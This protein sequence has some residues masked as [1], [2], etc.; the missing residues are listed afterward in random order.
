MPASTVPVSSPEARAYCD[1]IQQFTTQAD[2]D[3]FKAQRGAVKEG[4]GKFRAPSSMFLGQT[5]TLQLAVGAKD[6]PDP[7]NSL[8][9]LSGGTETIQPQVG[10][11]MMAELSGE[12]FTVTPSGPQQK[13]L[14]LGSTVVWTWTVHAD[15]KG[16]HTLVLTTAVQGIGADGRLVS[17]A[18]TNLNTPITVKVGFWQSVMD[19]LNA[20]P[21]WLKALQAVVAALTALAVAVFGLI[22]VLKK[23][24]DPTDSPNDQRSVKPR[25]RQTVRKDPPAP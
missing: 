1:E 20:A 21:V 4:V 22:K 24:G 3:A 15:A 7:E 10:R 2:C 6:G 8:N 11:H 16:K 5:V 18:D 12:G 19:W 14:P 13:D 25:G 23:R 9:G 17:L